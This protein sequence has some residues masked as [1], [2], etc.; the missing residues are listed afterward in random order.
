LLQ[1]LGPTP[2][3]DIAAMA[4]GMLPAEKLRRVAEELAQLRRGHDACTRPVT[5]RQPRHRQTPL[6]PNSCEERCEEK[7]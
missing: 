7:R 4:G 1:F 2:L 3:I 6:A 5:G